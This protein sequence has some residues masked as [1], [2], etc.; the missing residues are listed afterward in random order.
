MSVPRFTYLWAPDAGPAR[1]AVGGFPFNHRT[2]ADIYAEQDAQAERC[3]A[4]H[5]GPGGFD[6]RV[7]QATDRARA[8]VETR[9]HLPTSPCPRCGARGLCGHGDRIAA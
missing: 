9:T 8:T 1:A 7:G 2:L 3:K 6:R 4:S 5:K